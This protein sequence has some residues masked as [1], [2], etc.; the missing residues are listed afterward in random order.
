M[1]DMTSLIFI[2]LFHLI[3]QF[4]SIFKVIISIKKIELINATESCLSNIFSVE[5]IHW[6][7]LTILKTDKDLIC[8]SIFSILRQKAN[9]KIFTWKKINVTKDA[10]FFLLRALAHHNFTFN[11][12]F[13]YELKQKVRFSKSVCGIF[14]FWFR[15]VFIKLFV[16]QKPWTLWL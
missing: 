2:D 16:Q 8:K 5:D 7:L 6:R 1:T 13:F 9:A 10:L 12:W 15:L 4:L 3:F 11:L 14:H